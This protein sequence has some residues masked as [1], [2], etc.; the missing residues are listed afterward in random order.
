MTPVLLALALVAPSFLTDTVAY[1]DPKNDEQ[2]ADVVR[3]DDARGLPIVIFLHGGV[4]QYGS[5]Q[6]TKNVGYAFASRGFV[7]VNASY[8]LAP[9]H[10]WPAAIEDA[11]AVFAAVKKRAV[12]FGGDPDRIFVVGHSAGGQLA[13]LLLYD[14]QWLKK[15]GLTPAAIAGVVNLSGVFD[16][17]AALDEDQDD[18]GFARFVAPVFGTDVAA[19]RAASPI[20]VARRTGTPLLFVSPTEDYQAMREQTVA[21]T[22]ALSLLGEHAPVVVSLVVEGRTHDTL[23]SELGQPG[24][25]ATDGVVRFINDALRAQKTKGPTLNPTQPTPQ[26]STPPTTPQPKK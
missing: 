9:A 8:R 6:A 17:R 15:Q 3:T 24:D 18:G 1:G 11:A 21:M 23:V 10:K 13:M 14:P 7:A 16:L 2:K 20:D 25:R 4:W 19:L 22:R 26:P 5:R 12:E